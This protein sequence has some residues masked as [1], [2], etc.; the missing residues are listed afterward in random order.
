MDSLVATGYGSDDPVSPKGPAIPMEAPARTS[1]VIVNVAPAVDVLAPE[2]KTL[3]INTTYVEHN[4]TY[5]SMYKEAEVRYGRSCDCFELCGVRD[6]PIHTNARKLWWLVNQHAIV[7][8]LKRSK[9]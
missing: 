7:G 9:V 4:P 8:M 1:G 5:E 2:T 6:L 3:S